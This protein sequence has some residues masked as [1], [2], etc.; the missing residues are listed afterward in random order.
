MLICFRVY[1][2]NYPIKTLYM[3]NTKEFGSRS[4]EDYYMA[5]GIELIYSIPYEH[6]QNGFVELFIRHIQLIT[7]SLLFHANFTAFI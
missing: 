6:V 5:K 2:P 3:N 7:Q 4:F 1:F